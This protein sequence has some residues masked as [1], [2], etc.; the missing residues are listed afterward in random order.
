MWKSPSIR[1]TTMQPDSWHPTLSSSA[2]N[3]YGSVLHEVGQ[4]VGIVVVCGHPLLL[5]HRFKKPAGAEKARSQH[6]RQTD[7]ST[8]LRN[9]LAFQKPSTAETVIPAASKEGPKQG[10][11]YAV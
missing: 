4:R 8:A 10:E 3:H 7:R 1:L 9:K 6:D 2:G 5:P 11:I